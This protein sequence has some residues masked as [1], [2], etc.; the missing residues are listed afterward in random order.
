MTA[1][2]EASA[3]NVLTVAAVCNPACHFQRGVSVVTSCAADAAGA[4]AAGAAPAAAAA[5]LL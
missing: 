1:S 4:G 3:I 2:E 5:A